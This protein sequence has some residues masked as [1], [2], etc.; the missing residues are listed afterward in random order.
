MRERRSPWSDERGSVLVLAIFIMALL[1]AAGMIMLRMSASET[2]IAYNTVWAEGTFYAAEAAIAIGI[3]QLGPTLVADVATAATPIAN[4]YTRASN[5]L[6]LGATQQPNYALNSGLATYT[7]PSNFYFNQY[8]IA[9]TGTGPRN[10][11]RQLEI[12]ATYGPVQ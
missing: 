10:A 6:Y 7:N 8:R 9:G 2:D 1:L 12:Q 5:V 4:D 3:D 11:Q